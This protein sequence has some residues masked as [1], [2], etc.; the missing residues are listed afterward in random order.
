MHHSIFS[1][2]SA[3]FTRGSALAW[4]LAAV[5][6]TGCAT[7]SNDGPVGKTLEFLGL[8]APQS[9]DEVKALAPQQKKLTL[10]VHAGDQLNVDPQMRSLSVVMRV[11]KLRRTEAF[12]AAPYAA[13]GDAEAEKTAFGSDLVEAREVV[14]RP[15]QRYEVVETMPLDAGYVAVAALFRAPA[16]GRWRFAFE[17]KRAAASG[18]TLGLHGCAISVATGA[19]EK[20]PPEMLR[21]AGVKCS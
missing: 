17:S 2:A 14:M 7:A 16:E 8:K 5:G 20:T 11:Y 10:R 13:F 4:V 12:L 15:G 6:V 9:V 3:L 1:L 21:L 18:V 19:P